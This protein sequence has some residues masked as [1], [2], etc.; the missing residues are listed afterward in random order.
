M[1][2]L[3]Y[4]F[5]L[6]RTVVEVPPSWR[7]LM[8]DGWRLAVHPRTRVSCIT[9]GGDD[10]VGWVIGWAIAGSGKV[11]DSTLHLN[12]SEYAA[13]A[14]SRHK[15]LASLEAEL[16]RSAGRFVLVATMHGRAKVYT[17]ASASLGVVFSQAAQVVASTTTLIAPTKNSRTNTT[18]VQALGLPFK[19]TWFPFG[20]TARSDI[21]RLLPNHALDL[22]TWS[23]ERI[24][25]TKTFVP[26][27]PTDPM[28][29]IGRIA[30]TVEANI[31]AAVA[32][33]PVEMSLTAG[34]DSR[35]L[36]ACSRPW[37]DQIKFC[38][39]ALPDP[40]ARLDCDIAKR[41]AVRG[42]LR[43]TI[44]PWVP[45]S[46]QELADWL[47]RTGTSLAGRVWKSAG[48]DARLSDDDKISLTGL[49]G[50]V[51]RAY[52]WHESDSE[53]SALSPEEILRRI[54]LPADPLIV[55]RL[56]AWWDS[57]PV[58]GTLAKLDLLY[59][60][61]RLGC[62]AGP[63]LYGSQRRFG[64]SPFNSRRI[65]EAML[66]LP[67]DLRR[68]DFL[69]H[70]LIQQKWP[71]L[72]DLPFNTPV[73]WGRHLWPLRVRAWFVMQK[74]REEGVRTVVKKVVTRVSRGRSKR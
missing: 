10:P 52:Y 41:L 43:Y 70:A 42:K 58:D 48:V 65:F 50:E 16:A 62:W 61:Q 31:G 11:I 30:G 59:I 18:L 20:L 19:D 57:V 69:P 27:T 1:S 23:T 53:E 24:W 9:C 51:G 67:T 12:D 47:E 13:Y 46:Q 8:Q 5:V 63:S 72:L 64:L 26:P 40:T 4:Q 66:S 39:V 33:R 3:P 15:F 36:L 32:A 29:T 73:G 37:L 71:E 38:T 60:E 74:I 14:A 6:A 44:T 25:P 45:A 49:A 21:E 2:E 17:D 56:K 55:N 7:V 28:E 68:N 35:M 22:A 34:R 54:G